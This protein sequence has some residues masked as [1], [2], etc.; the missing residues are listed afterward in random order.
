MKEIQIGYY[1]QNEDWQRFVYVDG[2]PP[3]ALSVS[4]L[5][6]AEEAASVTQPVSIN[7]M[8]EVGNPQ[9]LTLNYWVEADHDLNLNGEPDD[10]EYV[11]KSVYIQRMPHLKN[12]YNLHRP[13]SKP[14][15]G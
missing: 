14:K 7:I 4:P 3:Q 12:L 8:D 15:Y 13:F 9:G 2:T 10:E 5:E 11:N 6:D 1:F